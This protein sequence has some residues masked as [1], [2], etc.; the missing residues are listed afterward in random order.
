MPTF[1]SR[2]SMMFTAVLIIV[3]AIF[4]Y[5]IYKILV[6]ENFGFNTD[7]LIPV[8]IMT[9]TAV[10]LLSL[11]VN[12][13]YEL[14]DNYLSYTSGPFHGKIAID[15]IKK[16]KVNTT[17]Y[18]GFKPA[19][20]TKGLVIYYNAFDDIYISPNSNESFV[21]ELLELNPK[22]EVFEM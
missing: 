10:F 16:V 14:F 20:A 15:S 21:K 5:G 22:I 18:V 4:G 8:S 7:T 11:F 3:L 1:K 2:N 9:L 19:L 17:R 6:S 12:T 13:K